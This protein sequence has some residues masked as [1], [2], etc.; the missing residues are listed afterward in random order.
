M[1][2]NQIFYLKIRAVWRNPRQSTDTVETY[3]VYACRFISK[4]VVRLQPNSI[5]LL[6]GETLVIGHSSTYSNVNQNSIADRTYT[7][8]WE[9]PGRLNETC[10][11]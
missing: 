9:C 5:L 7:V 6:K 3:L 8:R 10:S 4:L 2:L 1:P 11:S